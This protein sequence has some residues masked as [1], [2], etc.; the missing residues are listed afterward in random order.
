MEDL[1]SESSGALVAQ[2]TLDVKT[3]Q[4]QRHVIVAARVPRPDAFDGRV[5]ALKTY[6]FL[7]SAEFGHLDSLLVNLAPEVCLVSG[8]GGARTTS[9]DAFK[10][11]KLLEKRGIQ[12]RNVQKSAFTREGLEDDLRRLTGDAHRDFSSL[13]D[14]PLA[15]I[16]CLVNELRIVEEVDLCEAGEASGDLGA[17][18]ARP[19]AEKATCGGEGSYVIEAGRLE[20]LMRLDSAAAEAVN[21]LP[22]VDHPSA[23]G[24]LLGILDHC[25]TRM[26][27]RLLERWLRQPLVDVRAIE[28]RLSLTEVF[29][30]DPVLCD[31]L[32]DGPLR[33]CPDLELLGSRIRNRRG[34]LVELFKLYTFCQAGL[35]ALLDCLSNAETQVD[36]VV[37]QFL[38]PLRGLQNE[39]RMYQ[40]LIE[41]VVD[42]DNLPELRVNP[43]F[44]PALADLK[45]SLDR[46]AGEA[47][48][49]YAE[50]Q[51]EFPGLNIRFESSKEHGFIFRLPGAKDQADL[52][53]A[54]GRVQ[55]VQ[56]LKNGTYFTTPTLKQAA[57]EW[58]DVSREYDEAQTDLVHSALETAATYLPLVEQARAVLSKM[59]VLLSFAVAAQAA[60]RPYVRP[61]FQLGSDDNSGGYCVRE[62][63]HPCVEFMDDVEFIANDYVL[64]RQESRFHIITGPNM[65]GKS[66]YIR[67][68]GCISV[69]AQ[70]G[71]F[72]PCSEAKLPVLDAVLARVGASDAQQ[73]GISTFMA[74]MLDASGIL[75]SATEHSLVL[76][77]ELGRGTSTMD[78]FGLAWAISDH[79]L[80]TNKSFCLFAT[81]FHEVTA[82]DAEPGVVNRHVAASVLEDKDITFLYEVRDGPCLESYGVHCAALAGMPAKVV[83]RAR[84][85]A[86][87]LEHLPKRR[88][89]AQ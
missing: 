64:D 85:K 86:E 8:L 46:V 56:H 21:L 61:E 15:G 51:Q 77:D 63:R 60:P 71:S 59:D 82:L 30:K 50:V 68:L 34:G 73:R 38:E 45:E 39:L 76:I 6:S 3:K 44:N 66:T 35:P 80:K 70:I 32:R 27:K 18:L 28:D 74:E 65:G 75:G 62:A 42:M 67:A 37:E 55:I 33:G 16:A 79:I 54:K 26:G 29:V 17:N 36:A 10:I 78:G 7:D 25:K 81:H 83:A 1:G 84:E 47:E 24:S 13:G 4:Q 57:R 19:G 58:M 14:R 53:R 31:A 9:S 2:M 41:H 88:K 48:A 87:E 69:M 22:E 11:E 12:L 52:R 72:V 40:K 49:A 43:R 89:L 5:W 23:H 20:G